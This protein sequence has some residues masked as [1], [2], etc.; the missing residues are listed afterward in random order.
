MQGPNDPA[1]SFRVLMI[2]QHLYGSF[3]ISCG[4][5]DS[6]GCNLWVLMIS[7]LDLDP[8]LMVLMIPYLRVLITQQLSHGC[9]DPMLRS[10]LEK[11]PTLHGP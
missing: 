7:N 10:R 5:N 4:P 1:L 6:T 9:N 8:K 11:E 3:T 2:S